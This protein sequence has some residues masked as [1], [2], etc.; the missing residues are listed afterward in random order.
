MKAPI[1]NA[2]NNN[3]L[4][5]SAN[6]IIYIK[7]NLP[8]IEAINNNYTRFDY[9]GSTNFMDRHSFAVY[10]NANEYQLNDN[11]LTI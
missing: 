1:I 2:S 8:V 3:Q 6:A 5:I 9:V 4:I 10:F 11:I 7:I